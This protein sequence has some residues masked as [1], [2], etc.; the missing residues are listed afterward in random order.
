MSFAPLLPGWLVLL[1]VLAM[2]GSTAWAYRRPAWPLLP[3]VL[4]LALIALFLLEPVRLL[5]DHE[6]EPA[7]L[8]MLLDASA[9][10]GAADADG[11]ATRFAAASA[12][13]A[14]IGEQAG[15]RYRVEWMGLSAG[16]VPGRP[17]SPAQ[18]G[19][20][21]A[22]DG[23][24]AL[25]AA[26]H[27]PMAIVLASDGG[28]RGPTPPDAALAAARVPV[29]CVGVGSIRA[30]TN[31]AVRLE[32]ASTSAFP[33]QDMGLTAIVTAS[34]DLVGRQA[35]LIIESEDESVDESAGKPTGGTAGKSPRGAL[36]VQRTLI[37]A[38]ETRVEAVVAV[39]DIPGERLYRARL[40]PLPDEATVEDDVSYAEVRVIDRKLR[41]LLLEGQP[42]WDSA[43][44]VRALRRDR[45]LGAV[46]LQKVGARTLRSGDASDAGDT[47]EP[48]PAAA[49]AP[50]STE[51][52]IDGKMFAAADVIIL[53][54]EVER[55]MAPAALAELRS[56]VAGG[57]G[58]VML[59]LGL[60]DETLAALDPVLHRRGEPASMPPV[61]AL[62]GLRLAL[63]PAEGV[64]LAPVSVGAS[65]GL[66]PLAEVLLGD[67]LHPAVAAIR[68]GAGHV[69]A[70]NAEG[71]W[72]WGLQGQVE[73]AE[74]F[75]RQLVKA[76][77]RNGE[78]PLRP[79]R[80][81][82]RAGMQATVA[83][84]N[85]TAA[86]SVRGPDGRESSVSAVAGVAL[87]AL[88][89]PGL[90]R[91]TRSGATATLVVD[92]DVREIADLPR[93]DDRLAR[94]AA[95]TGGELIDAAAALD[96]GARLA[97]RAD[98]QIEAPRTEQLI[99]HAWWMPV[100]AACLCSEWWLRRR[101]HGVV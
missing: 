67:E 7:R 16:L 98:L 75:W 93:R 58:L 99:T 18:P 101:R 90:Y 2:A 25:A 79:D 76:V 68:H 15:P 11:A 56:Y 32:A 95:A 86:V 85:G 21:T 43:C 31:A 47:G 74:R 91:L 84:A 100:L 62:A 33:G 41:V 70:V 30:A 36:L 12:A 59:G 66:R 51:T 97:R 45:Q 92:A 13:L 26:E 69:V 82:Y 50:S 37:L 19:D 38:A 63:L 80:P 53:G 9:S 71:L 46:T 39:G 3:R 6:H 42:Y 64:K 27:P 29:F 10:M 60:R 52:A 24:A 89:E 87:I 4:A 44:A 1:A 40:T 23:M 14:R 83:L 94:L 22:Y 77:A 55:L 20:G 8:V 28:D 5:V 81:R 49:D 65:D 72:R 57:G 17:A 88:P 96:L 34:P 73:V 61:L 48:R 35:Q 78:E 54:A